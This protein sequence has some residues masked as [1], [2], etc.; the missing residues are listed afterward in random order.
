MAHS[1]EEGGDR[2]QRDEAEGHLI[3]EEHGFYRG[4]SFEEYIEHHHRQEGGGWHRQ[5]SEEDQP[6]S[7]RNLSDRCYDEKALNAT[8]IEQLPVIAYDVSKTHEMSECLVC[9]SEFE[10][11]QPLTYLPC[12]HYF[13]KECI[14]NWL[15]IKAECPL[16]KSLV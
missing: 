9:T 12:F 6:S 7:K 4:S 13:H 11:G 16:C 8:G 15:L 1:F 14:T 3:P 10:H 2:S 5:S